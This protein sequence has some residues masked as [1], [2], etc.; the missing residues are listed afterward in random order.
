MESKTTWLGLAKLLWL[1]HERD[2]VGDFGKRTLMHIPVGFVI[3]LLPFSG[4]LKDLFISYE[5]NE[6]L[7]TKDEAW[8]DYFGAIVGYIPGRL[9]LVGLCVWL[10]L[11]LLGRVV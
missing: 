5:E 2:K 10:A 6:D 11:L 7:H 9:V 4:G 1:R 3:G 8:K